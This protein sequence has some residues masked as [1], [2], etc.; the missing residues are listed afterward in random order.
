M[1]IVRISMTNNRRNP[2]QDNAMIP[3][4]IPVMTVSLIANS[5]LLTFLTT[6]IRASVKMAKRNA[7]KAN[8]F[9]LEK[10]DELIGNAMRA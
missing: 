8:S 1:T 2:F 7:V 10:T 6:L 4:M 5:S 9:P 3:R